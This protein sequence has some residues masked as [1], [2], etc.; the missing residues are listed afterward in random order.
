MLV[1][2]LALTLIAAGLPQSD[3][4]S[5]RQAEVRRVRALIEADYSALDSVLADDLVYTHSTAKVDTKTSYLEP[6][7]SGRTRYRA[8][9]ASDV[10]VRIYG[11]TAVITG[12]MRSL[13][14]VAGR[15]SRTHMRFTSVWVQRDTRWQ[16]VT[17]QSTRIPEP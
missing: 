6:L 14:L 10:Q 4:E 12:A 1:L 16:M 5:V 3:V 9:D 8:L 13:A 2:T 7:L 11:N 17:W 15:E